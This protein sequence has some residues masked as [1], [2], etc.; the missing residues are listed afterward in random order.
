MGNG[1]NINVGGDLPRRVYLT[2]IVTDF[3]RPQMRSGFKIPNIKEHVSKHRYD[4]IKDILTIAKAYHVAGKPD[5]R[6][7]D[8]EKGKIREIPNM[9]SFEEW[10]TYIGGMLVMIGKLDFLGNN[11]DVLTDS[12]SLN[13]DGEV[14]LLKIN[15]TIG[16]DEFTASDIIKN[17]IYDGLVPPYVLENEKSASKKLGKFFSHIKGR[18]FSSGCKIIATRNVMHVQKWVVKIVKQES[19]TQF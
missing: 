3:A 9:G 2:R 15:G 16:E 7:T 10:R 17:N 4:Y 19:Q 14:L 12:E 1:I 5:P 11:E 6:W 13:V 18:V 8:K